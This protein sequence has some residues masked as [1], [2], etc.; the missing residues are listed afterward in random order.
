MTISD[1]QILRNYRHQL[2]TFSTNCFWC[3]GPLG[4]P[5]NYIV[6]HWYPRS[7]GGP[8][9]LWNLRLVHHRCFIDNQDTVLAEAKEAFERWLESTGHSLEQIL[10]A[11][12]NVPSDPFLNTKRKWDDTTNTADLSSRVKSK[13]KNWI[14]YS[15]AKARRYRPILRKTQTSCYW[16]HRIFSAEEEP[17]VDHWYPLSRGGPTELWNLK[18]MHPDCNVEKD[19]RILEEAAEAYRVWK[20]K[21]AL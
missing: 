7:K 2:E 18:L 6:S 20:I 12:E 1:R 4:D 9:S 15:R 5:S 21:S 8:T 13:R 17:T 3:R 14:Q 19:D 16:C 11:L 10:E